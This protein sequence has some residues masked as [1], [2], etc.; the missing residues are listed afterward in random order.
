M[1]PDLKAVMT[2][3][4][5]MVQTYNQCINP[6]AASAPIYG[7]GYATYV[8]PLATK[9]QSGGGGGDQFNQAPN[10]AYWCAPMVN[11]NPWTNTK[12]D[13]GI[14]PGKSMEDINVY[15]QDQFQAM[16]KSPKFQQTLAT[17]MKLPIY[18]IKEQ[19]INLIR[20]HSVLIIKGSTGCG[21]T[22]QVCV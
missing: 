13:D 15:L 2:Q 20:D 11:Y 22:T 14:F 17:R 9:H 16:I 10:Y 5:G 4:Y 7:P 21:K 3:T 8:N 18:C 19:V 6:N 12:P 1:K